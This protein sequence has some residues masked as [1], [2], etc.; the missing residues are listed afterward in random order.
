MLL[1]SG[2]VSGRELPPG[3]AFAAS[4]AALT[5]ALTN[6]SGPALT[7]NAQGST[8]KATP[9]AFNAAARGMTV[10]VSCWP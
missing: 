3:V 9:D 1:P 2:A 7:L 4:A 6:P 5:E 8:E 10:L